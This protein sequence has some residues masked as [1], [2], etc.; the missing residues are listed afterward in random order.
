MKTNVKRLL[1]VTILT[2]TLGLLA[3]CAAV[4]PTPSATEAIPTATAMATA[5]ATATATMVKAT[6]TATPAATVAVALPTATATAAEPTATSLQVFHAEELA[7]Y[8]GLN[9]N[10]AYVAVDGKVYDV[11]GIARWSN[12]SHAGGTVLAGKDQTEALKRSPHG[13]KNLENLPIVGLY[14]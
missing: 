3:G 9:G 6:A 5:T 13:A 1:A 4:A 14:E 10:A 11:T 8:D 7:K 2:L 12:G